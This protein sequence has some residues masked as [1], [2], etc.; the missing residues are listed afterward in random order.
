MVVAS[1]E[2]AGWQVCMSSEFIL[3]HNQAA[4]ILFLRCEGIF[5]E[6]D[7]SRAEGSLVKYGP[8]AKFVHN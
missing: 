2:P 5:A 4:F 3:Y 8:E 1:K 7:G 6:R